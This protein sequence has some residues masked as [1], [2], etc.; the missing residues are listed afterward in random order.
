MAQALDQQ[1]QQY[2]PLLGEEEKRSIL[3]VIKSFISLHNEGAGRSSLEQYNEETDAALAR[4]RGG[5]FYSQD[6]S[7]KAAAEW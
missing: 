3:S 4:V 2:L 1:I 5:S 7:E 6:E